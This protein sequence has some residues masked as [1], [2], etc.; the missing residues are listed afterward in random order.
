MMMQ[1][2]RNGKLYTNWTTPDGRPY[3]P[4][5]GALAMVYLVEDWNGKKYVG[6]KSLTDGTWVTYRTSCRQLKGMID[7]TGEA[8]NEM[9]QFIVL[10][11]CSNEA[12]LRY[13]ELH[14][15]IRHNTILDGYNSGVKITMIGKPDMTTARRL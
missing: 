10:W 2:N 8:I 1:R 7:N 6:K 5:E 11:E 3:Q 14:E 9:F 13:L 15:I 12:T 4:S